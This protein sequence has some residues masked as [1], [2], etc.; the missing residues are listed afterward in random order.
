MSQRL[1]KTIAK[2]IGAIVL[3]SV[4]I[5]WLFS[6]MQYSALADVLALLLVLVALAWGVVSGETRNKRDEIFL[7]Q[8]RAFS[9]TG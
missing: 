3:T 7:H 1:I 5:A 2:H 6:P 4:L 9:H 8:A